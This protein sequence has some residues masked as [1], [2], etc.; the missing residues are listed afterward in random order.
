MLA[1]VFF[2]HAVSEKKPLSFDSG[3]FDFGMDYSST[4]ASGAMPVAVPS[5]ETS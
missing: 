4:S 1:L 3:F 5:A 2:L